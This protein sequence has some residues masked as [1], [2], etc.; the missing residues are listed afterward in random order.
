MSDNAF[1]KYYRT[2]K[3]YVTIPSGLVHYDDSVIEVKTED[4]TVP[5]MAMTSH[6]ELLFKNPDA[7]LNGEAVKQ[8]LLS[9]IPGLKMPEKLYSND[10]DALLA[11]I[12]IHSYGP[13]MPI[14]AT[15]PNCKDEKEHDLNL[16][17]V[18][19][20]M[21]TMDDVYFVN[22]DNGLTVFVHPH[23]FKETMKSL[24][25]GFEQAKIAKSMEDQNVDESVKLAQF[26]KSFKEIEKLNF[27]L[28]ASC[29]TKVVNEDDDFIFTHEGT[30]DSNDQLK[31]LLN[32]IDV[33]DANKI[34]AKIADITDLGIPKKF[35]ISCE[36]CDHT[37]TAPLELNPVNFFTG[38]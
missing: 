21:D 3:A 10:V 19:A 6:D 34:N 27:E 9:C 15:C 38:S 5:I 17:A 31:M 28:I 33:T 7:L 35:D 22:L 13:L 23:T 20:N 11:S 30:K 37:W 14:N 16:E 29:I 26:S 12:K 1:G 8:V 4:N 36:K 18:M 24:T 25:V 32:N 2:I